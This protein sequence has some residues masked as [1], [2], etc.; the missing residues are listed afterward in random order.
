MTRT[1]LIVSTL[2]MVS[3]R[4]GVIVP[5]MAS[6]ST[7]RLEISEQVAPESC[8]A[9]VAKRCEDA[10]F[11]RNTGDVWR[12]HLISVS[13]EVNNTVAGGWDD[14]QAACVRVLCFCWQVAH[15]VV[16]EQAVER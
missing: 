8:T 15:F 11:D 3:M 16:D 1:D 5:L 13:L 14:V 7:A 10:C 2:L 4:N 12:A 6:F 9:F